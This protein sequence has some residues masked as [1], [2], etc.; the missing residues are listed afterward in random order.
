M[1]A[2]DPWRP[3]HVERACFIV[4]ETALDVFRESCNSVRDKSSGFRPPPRTGKLNGSVRTIVRKIGVLVPGNPHLI[5]VKIDLR[6][7][8]SK[9]RQ[10]TGGLNTH[11]T[12]P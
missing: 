10:C 8:Q 5:D 12:P 1:G 3:R 9:G 2:L 4:K 11:C 7:I 6:G